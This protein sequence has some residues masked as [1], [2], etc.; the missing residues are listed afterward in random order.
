[1]L[2]SVHQPPEDMG[3]ETGVLP[4]LPEAGGTPALEYEDTITLP[5][6][7]LDLLEELLQAQGHEIAAVI[8][9]S[10]GPSTHSPAGCSTF[11][12]VTPN[13]RERPAE[14]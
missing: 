7:R 6:N 3:P 12:G 13:E 8:H 5:W 4:T 1:M 2:V 14:E 10:C 11:I 9:H